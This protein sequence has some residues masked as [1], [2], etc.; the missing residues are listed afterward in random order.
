MPPRFKVDFQLSA[1]EQADAAAFAALKAGDSL[2]LMQHS[3]EAATPAEEPPAP[4]DAPATTEAPAAEAAE[5]PTADAM[6]VDGSAEA[7]AE[8]GASTQQQPE[9]APTA[10]T[11]VVKPKPAAACLAVFSSSGQL[12][13]VVP[14]AVAGKLP[15]KTP[16]F[17]LKVRSVKRAAGGSGGVE[18][19]LLRFEVPEPA[20]R[21]ATGAGGGRMAH[22]WRH[23]MGAWAHGHMAFRVQCLAM[24]PAK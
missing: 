17:E 15:I 20:K 18:S 12:L 13:G 6:V 22:A 14:A 24:R 8:D 21:A 4:A 5:A 16:H 23:R 10:T 2:T 19:A 1:H 11:T 3:F 7:A 9:V